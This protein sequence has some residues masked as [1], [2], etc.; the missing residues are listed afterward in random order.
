MLNVDLVKF[1][2]VV[3]L[4]CRI[5]VVSSTVADIFFFDF[6]R[7]FVAVLL[8]FNDVFLCFLFFFVL[9][10]IDGNELFTQNANE[11]L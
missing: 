10:D 7:H 1:S 2:V 5:G 11:L 8:S 6:L 3:R 9:F 4:F